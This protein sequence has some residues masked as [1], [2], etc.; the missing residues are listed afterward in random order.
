MNRRDMPSSTWTTAD[1]MCEAV[2]VL[3]AY[4]AEVG[5]LTGAGEPVDVPYLLEAE[6]LARAI[7]DT[8]PPF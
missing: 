8:Q 2:D 5:R 6:R 7:T 4:I 1:W 3:T